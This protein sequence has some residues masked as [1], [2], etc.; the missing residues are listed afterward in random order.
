MP[1]SACMVAVGGYGRQA[2]FPYSDVDVLVLLPDGISPDSDEVLKNKVETFIGSCWDTGLEIGSS[3][4]NLSDCI[5]EAQADITVQT[6]MLES[7]FLTGNPDL[8][9][10]FEHSFQTRLDARTFFT[11]KTLEMQQRHNKFENSPYSLEPNCKESPG[12]LRDLQM[13][14]WLARASGL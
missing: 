12:G 9:Q 2:L 4:R 11:G 7:R 14:L 6:A 13:L 1:D 8:M 3:V 10:S 5:H